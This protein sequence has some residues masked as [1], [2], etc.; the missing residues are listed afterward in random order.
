MK[1]SHGLISKLTPRATIIKTVW[2]W[3]KDRHIDQWSRIESSEINLHFYI[4]SYF[5][6][7]D[8]KAI[9]CGEIV[10]ITNGVGTIGYPH[11]NNE[12]GPY[13]I[14]YIKFNAKWIQDL[15]VR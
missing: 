2:C 9:Q 12:V 4:N 14:P 7:K 13:L 15:N 1:Y 11:A 8:T 10:F 6:N 5:F 3:H